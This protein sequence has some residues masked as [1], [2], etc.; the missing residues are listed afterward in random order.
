MRNFLFLSLICGSMTAAAATRQSITLGKDETQSVTLQQTKIK[1]RTVFL[2][3]HKSL[4][5]G[6]FRRVIPK[7]TYQEL[8]GQMAQRS[9]ILESKGLEQ[10]LGDCADSILVTEDSLT[11]R[12]CLQGVEGAEKKK[13]IQWFNQTAGM[14]RL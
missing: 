6:V 2:L 5:N 14:T 10:V 12:L 13:F 3:T 9:R 1:N 8:S 4:R 11:K 7:E